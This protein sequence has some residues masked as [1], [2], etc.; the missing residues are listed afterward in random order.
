MRELGPHVLRIR[1]GGPADAPLV[2][3]IAEQVFAHFG[4]YGRILPTWLLHEGVITHI[5][6]EGE[7]AVGYTMLGFYPIALVDG[8]AAGEGL[9]ADLLAIAVA[10]EAQGRGVGKR[11]LQHAIDHVRAARRR[12]TIRELRLSVAD[13]NTRA[14]RL[15]T[16]YGFELVDG[17]HGFYDGGQV[18][19]HMARKL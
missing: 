7:R 11:L 15:F 16:R 1:R 14:R 6:E 4:D 12:L 3:A 5:A 10:P 9:V 17:E 13:T 2:R 19:L 18:A 8:G